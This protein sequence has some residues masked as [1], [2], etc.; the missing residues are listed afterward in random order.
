MKILGQ[1]LWGGSVHVVSAIQLLAGWLAPACLGPCCTPTNS[2]GSLDHSGQ[3]C[4]GDLLPAGKGSKTATITSLSFIFLGL[5]WS[6]LKLV[7]DLC[8]YILP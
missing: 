7:S 5:T 8:Q 4:L 3:D 2:I 6:W 1:S